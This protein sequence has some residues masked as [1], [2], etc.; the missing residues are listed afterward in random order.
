M[1]AESLP[2]EFKT[3]LIKETREPENAH[4]K[5]PT[6]QKET[7][8]THTKEDLQEKSKDLESKSENLAKNSQDKNQNT[9]EIAKAQIEIKDFTIQDNLANRMKILEQ[10]MVN[11]Q[12]KQHS[13]RVIGE[14]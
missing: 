11:I 5:Q 1:S 9:Q 13:K 12:R 6:L 2:K 8:N 3:D 7:Q 10:N 4:L 14:R